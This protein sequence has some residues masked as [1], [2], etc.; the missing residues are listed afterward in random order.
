MI[1]MGYT[2]L[3]PEGDID[4]NKVNIIITKGLANVNAIQILDINTI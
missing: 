2:A 4:I 3:I 1:H